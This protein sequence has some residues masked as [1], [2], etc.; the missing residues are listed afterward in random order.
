MIL[1]D[2]V[3]KRYGNTVALA[4]TSITFDPQ[5]TSV[6]IGPSGCGKSTLLRIIVGLIRADTGLVRLG[7]EVLTDANIDQARHRMGYVIQDGGL[8]P[9]LTAA[10]E[11]SSAARIPSQAGK[12]NRQAYW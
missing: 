8:F 6:L 10:A 2:N 12:C 9:H 5:T 3:S 4:P 11:C 1:V 7:D